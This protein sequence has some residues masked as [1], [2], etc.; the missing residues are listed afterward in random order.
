VIRPPRLQPGDV[1]RV[2]APSF[3]VPRERFEQGAALLAARYRLRYDPATLFRTER[4]FAGPDELRLA[5]LEAALRDPE[6]R[7]VIMARGGH[8]LLRLLPFLNPDLLRA[9]PKPLVGFSDGTLLCAFAARAG[10]ASI[11]GP[12]VAQL[13]RLPEEDRTALFGLLERPGSGLLLSELDAPVPGRI[14]GPLV[15]GNLEVFSRLLGTPHMPDPTGAILF[16]EDVDERP[17]RV[18]RLLTHLDLAG[19]FAVAAAVVVGEF[20][21]C[22]EPEGS[23]LDS[24]TVEEVLRDRLGR[25][26]IPVAFGAKIGHGDRNAPLPCGTLC[27][28]DTRHGTL[29]ALEGAVS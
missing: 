19:L 29:V 13:G 10:V 28:L 1:V 17:Y 3:A 20:T 6:A 21:A 27:E 18:D 11:H 4:Y 12:V 26:A 8:G 15:G 9:N 24:P 14:Q 16:F 2:I 7:A 5:E 23:K 25:L 22:K